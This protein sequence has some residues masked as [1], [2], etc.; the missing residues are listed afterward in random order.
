MLAVLAMAATFPTWTSATFFTSSLA[1]KTS[2]I[3]FIGLYVP[4]NPFA[5]LANSVFPAVVLFSTVMGTP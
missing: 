3:D 5:S 2:D 4:T 1:E